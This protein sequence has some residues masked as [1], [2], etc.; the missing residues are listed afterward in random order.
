MNKKQ[1]IDFITF[2]ILESKKFEDR[3][4]GKE[5]QSYLNQLN[6]R[7]LKVITSEFIL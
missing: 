4:Y 3:L 6:K 7:N 2:L 1:L 5:I